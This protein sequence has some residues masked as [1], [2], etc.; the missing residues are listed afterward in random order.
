MAGTRVTFGRVE[1]LVALLDLLRTNDLLANVQIEDSWQGPTA[2]EE[3]IYAG[4]ITGTIEAGPMRTGRAIHDD[5][6]V[7]PLHIEAG[8]TAKQKTSIDA[9]RRCEQLMSG[10]RQTVADRPNLARL[11]GMLSILLDSADGPD[12]EAVTDPA[13]YL[14]VGTVRVR[15]KIRM[16]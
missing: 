14:A 13:G 12:A 15:A 1:A 11:P 3:C 16:Q 2:K 10:V 5:E 8:K 4:P 7:I 9:R 6:F